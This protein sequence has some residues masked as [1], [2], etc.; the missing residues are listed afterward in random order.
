MATAAAAA[1][2]AAFIEIVARWHAAELERFPDFFRNALLDLADLILRFHEFAA[3]VIADQGVALGF[4]VAHFA[5]FELHALVLFVMQRLRHL[6][7]VLILLL[8]E[9]GRA[10]V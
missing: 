2:A 6:H 5:F 3:N 1:A 10:H 9:I 4:E 8:C 7:H